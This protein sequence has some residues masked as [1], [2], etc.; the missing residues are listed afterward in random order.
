MA[1]TALLVYIILCTGIYTPISMAH[2]ALLVY[3]I[4]CTGIY[5]VYSYILTY[6]YECT[7]DC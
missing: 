7:R 4:L 6:M 3:I 2:T 1:H 5:N